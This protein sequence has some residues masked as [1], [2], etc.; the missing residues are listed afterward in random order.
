MLKALGFGLRFINGV[1]ILFVDTP[2][3]LSISKGMSLAHGDFQLIRQVYYLALAL[4]ALF[5][6]ALSYLMFSKI[7]LGL[8][9]RIS[10]LELE[11]EQFVNGHFVDD[12]FLTILKDEA[13]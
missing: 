2:P 8:I 10:F 7:N 13:S 5:V 12:S 4:N 9:C 1:E 11:V 6:K 3:Y